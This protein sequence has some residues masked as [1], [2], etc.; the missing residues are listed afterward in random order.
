VW[1]WLIGQL[2]TPDRRTRAGRPVPAQI[3]VGRSVV[4]PVSRAEF[5]SKFVGVD[6]VVVVV[7]V[8]MSFR[9]ERRRSAGAQGTLRY[10]P[11]IPNWDDS[12][13]SKK[14]WQRMTVWPGFELC[15]IIGSPTFSA[16]RSW[17]MPSMVQV[18]HHCNVCSTCFHILFQ[19]NVR[20]ITAHGVVWTV[21]LKVDINSFPLI[22]FVYSRVQYLSKF[23][24]PANLRHPECSTLVHKNSRRTGNFPSINLVLFSDQSC[25]RPWVIPNSVTEVL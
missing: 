18:Q 13:P 4:W 2:A 5:V 20:L 16:A 25:T 3:A 22:L 12:V 23:S 17:R 21:F 24:I 7:D 1:N 15:G 19:I 11:L 10:P 8:G 14:H 6:D 9:R